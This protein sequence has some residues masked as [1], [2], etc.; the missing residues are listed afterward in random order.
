MPWVCVWVHGQVSMCLLAQVGD[1]QVCLYACM[2]GFS[3]FLC[4]GG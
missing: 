1:G 3:V 4:T 2:E